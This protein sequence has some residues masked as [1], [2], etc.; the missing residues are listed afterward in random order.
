VTNLLSSVA[1]TLI[2]I[3]LIA[4]LMLF[5]VTKQITKNHRRA[6]HLSMDISTILFI[7]SVHYLILAIWGYSAF[8][9]L[10]IIIIALALLVVV[11]HYKVKEEIDIGKV[12]KG[13]WRINFAFF[14]CAY[15][16]LVLL[17][18]AYRVTNALI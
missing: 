4:Y 17:G 13:F 10:L 11:V 12:A 16:I 9:L 14:F 18:L 3:P 5:M 8:W 1:A 15:F 2:T 6:A 7:L